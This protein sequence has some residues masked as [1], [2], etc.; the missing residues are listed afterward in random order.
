MAEDKKGLDGIVVK[1]AK[2]VLMFRLLSERANKAAAK[3]ALQ[4]SHTIKLD[5]KSESTVTKDG[6]VNSTGESTV[7]IE[8]EALQS[9]TDTNDLLEYAV[10]NGLTLEVWEIDFTKPV[11]A[12]KFEAKYGTGN[13]SGWE[14]PAAAEGN[15]TIK[16][17]MNINGKLVKGHATVS[18]E[19]E[20][21]AKLFFYDTIAGA[22]GVDPLPEYTG[23]DQKPTE[24]G[25]ET[26]TANNKN[27]KK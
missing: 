11:E 16:T 14:M 25:S 6:A 3:L 4:V 20:L 5:N 27:D 17:T 1:G 7:S 23:S 24:P 26:R 15:A 12:G 21:E 19:Q 18:A 2:K 9:D 22:E 8:L 10:S 13:L